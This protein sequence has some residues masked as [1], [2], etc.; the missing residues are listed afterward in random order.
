MNRKYEKILQ[1]H[2]LQF[3]ETGSNDCP[4]YIISGAG[5]SFH[6]PVSRFP[7]QFIQYCMQYSAFDELE[8]QIGG[9]SVGFDDMVRIKAR[10][11]TAEEILYSTAHA[12]IRAEKE[13]LRNTITEMNDAVWF[14]LAETMAQVWKYDGE[15]YTGWYNDAGYKFVIRCGG[16]DHVRIAIEEAFRDFSEEQYVWEQLKNIETGKRLQVPTAEL[17]QESEQVYG[18]LQE[19]VEMLGDEDT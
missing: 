15:Y 8:K 4:E 5:I 9:G 3:F 10:C 18:I 16:I 19:M 12:L 1:E 14:L 7:E 13:E 6:C 2:S 17:I 11:E